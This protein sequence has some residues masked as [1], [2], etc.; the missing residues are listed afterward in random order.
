MV[1]KKK[2]FFRRSTLKVK[3]HEGKYERWIRSSDIVYGIDIFFLTKKKTGKISF[4]LSLNQI[5]AY[6]NKN[7]FPTLSAFFQ[8]YSISYTYIRSTLGARRKRYMERVKKKFHQRKERHTLTHT[9]TSDFLY[10]NHAS[11]PNA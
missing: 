9:Y 7:Q 5:S 10:G 3:T 6:S 1:K 4:S 2:Q 11:W 8:R